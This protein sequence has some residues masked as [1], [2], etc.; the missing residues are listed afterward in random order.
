MEKS[1]TPEA[2]CALVEPALPHP[3]QPR[4]VFCP[5]SLA[6]REDLLKGTIQVA[7]SWRLAATGQLVRAPV[8]GDGH[9]TARMDHSVLSHSLAKDIGFVSRF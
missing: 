7:A 9:S 1:V 6:F 8:L 5:C 2:L 3:R 4:F